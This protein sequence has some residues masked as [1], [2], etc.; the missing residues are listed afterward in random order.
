MRNH[1]ANFIGLNKREKP[2]NIATA[3]RATTIK[4]VRV[5]VYVPNARDYGDSALNSCP[6][7]HCEYV[8]V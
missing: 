4:R 3:R 7:R 6:K 2:I 5:Y 8:R 1:H